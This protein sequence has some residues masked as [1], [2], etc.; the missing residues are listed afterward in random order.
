MKIIENVDDNKDIDHELKRKE[1]GLLNKFTQLKAIEKKDLNIL[2]EIHSEIKTL[3]ATNEAYTAKMT[4]DFEFWLDVMYKKLDWEKVNLKPHTDISEGEVNSTRGNNCS[5]LS[6]ELRE[7]S[8]RYNLT[9][10][11]IMSEIGKK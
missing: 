8:D 4:K 9:K 5:Q 10:S 7:I 6:S 3:Q 1:E 11:K 2:Q